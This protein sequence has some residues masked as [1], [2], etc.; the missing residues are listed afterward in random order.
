MPGNPSSS[1]AFA[2]P[3]RG[4]TPTSM[5]R[6]PTRNDP[7]RLRRLDRGRR[8]A[9]LHSEPR[10]RSGRLRRAPSALRGG[11][12]PASPHGTARHLLSTQWSPL[13]VP[14]L[15]A[16]LRTRVDRHH[17]LDGASY[18]TASMRRRLARPTRPRRA[19]RRTLQDPLRRPADGRRGRVQG[20][21]PPQLGDR[22][23]VRA[24]G[25]PRGRRRLL[26]RRVGMGSRLRCSGDILSVAAEM[27]AARRCS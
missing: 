7:D 6:R 12:Q 14:G 15:A 25:I 8:L 17:R 27:R 9:L 18:P 23:A 24:A 4:A 1:E 16:Q 10:R 3:A 26:V 21:H 19:G 13:P 11:G 2:T 5:S 22:P 20:V